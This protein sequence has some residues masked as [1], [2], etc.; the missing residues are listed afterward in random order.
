MERQIKR[1]EED[2][3]WNFAFLP[4]EIAHTN[5]VKNGNEAETSLKA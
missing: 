3:Y 5:Q 4:E 1:I 2:T